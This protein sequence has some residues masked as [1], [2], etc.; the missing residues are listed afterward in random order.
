M[1][2]RKSLEEY[3]A[4]K[5]RGFSWDSIICFAIA[6]I[7]IPSSLGRE[8]DPGRIWQK[9][10]LEDCCGSVRDGVWDTTC[11]DSGKVPMAWIQP[12]GLANVNTVTE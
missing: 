1:K 11:A 8:K 10:H 3:L 9:W 2:A 12:L 7:F 4:K 5:A 6:G